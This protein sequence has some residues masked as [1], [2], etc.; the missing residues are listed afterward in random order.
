LRGCFNRDSA[1]YYLKAKGGPDG[2]GG[3]ELTNPF[4][5]GNWRDNVVAT[6]LR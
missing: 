1:Y 3:D 4:D 5:R 6:L 2:Q